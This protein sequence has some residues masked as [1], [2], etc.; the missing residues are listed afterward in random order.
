MHQPI[1]VFPAFWLLLLSI[2]L[3]GISP[4]SAYPVSPPQLP[5]SDVS[6]HILRFVLDDKLPAPLCLFLFSCLLVYLSSWGI[7][8]I[9]IFLLVAFSKKDLCLLQ[10]SS[11]LAITKI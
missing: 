5:R 11:F 9:H 1:V 3:D 4:A 2:M 10:L 7:E 6:A 8:L